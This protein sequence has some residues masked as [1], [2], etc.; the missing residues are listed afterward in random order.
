MTDK[1]QLENELTNLKCVINQF[2]NNNQ[3]VINRWTNLFGYT[4]D[5]IV[6]DFNELV[7]V[8]NHKYGK[9]FGEKKLLI[10]N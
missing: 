7:K 3:V 9:R 8:Y 10:N 5:M 2:E 1:K 4:F 6:N